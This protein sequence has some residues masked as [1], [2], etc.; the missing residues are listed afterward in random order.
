M[1]SGKSLSW[2][3][4]HVEPVNHR[5][6]SKKIRR[7]SDRGSSFRILAKLAVLQGD[8]CRADR[9]EIPFLTVES[10]PGFPFAALLRFAAAALVRL[11]DVPGCNGI[12]TA[13][14]PA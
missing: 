14:V 6:R 10:V 8:S 13:T 4:I 11:F 7:T 12:Q 1:V 5:T 3:D 2:L 9:A